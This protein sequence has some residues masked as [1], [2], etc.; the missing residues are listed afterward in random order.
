MHSAEDVDLFMDRPKMREK[1]M[2][3][4]ALELEQKDKEQKEQTGEH[5]IGKCSKNDSTSTSAATTTTDTF[6]HKSLIPPELRILY[7]FHDGQNLPLTMQVFQLDGEDFNE[8]QTYCEWEIEKVMAYED[9]LRDW[10]CNSNSN[11]DED[12]NEGSN[13]GSNEDHLRNPTSHYAS[14]RSR[15]TTRT[16]FQHGY[17]G[18]PGYSYVTCYVWRYSISWLLLLMLIL[19]NCFPRETQMK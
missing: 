17:A 14:P 2:Q 12:S 8:T 4:Y 3:R 15:F 9:W 1:A 10:Y 13:E 19:G 6:L 16:P 11:E 5:D 18:R 7:R